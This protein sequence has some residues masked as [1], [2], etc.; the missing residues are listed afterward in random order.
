MTNFVKSLPQLSYNDKLFPEIV[1]EKK[2][3]SPLSCFCFSVFYHSNQNEASTYI[4][5]NKLGSGDGSV[6][7]EV[8]S[9]DPQNPDKSSMLL[10]GG[11]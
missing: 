3:L 5:K 6:D 8:Q 10:I 4:I 11:L 1:A 2:I 7:N 9:L